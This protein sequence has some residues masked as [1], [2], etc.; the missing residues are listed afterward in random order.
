[1][2]DIVRKIILVALGLIWLT[3]VYLIVVNAAKTQGEYASTSP[4]QATGLTGLVDNVVAAWERG[5]LGGAFTSTILYSVTGPIVAVLIGAAAGY[6]IV[7]LQL[8]RGF[9]WFV[10]IFCSSIF[11]IQML[12]MPLFFWYVDWH[13]YNTR[14]GLI[15]IYAVISVSFSAFVMRNFFTGI[16]HQVFEAAVVDG[17]SAWRIFW[18]IYLPL[19]RPALIALFILQAT[20]VWNDLLLGLTLTKSEEIRPLMASLAALTGNYGGSTAPILLAGGLIVSI[21]TVVLFLSTQRAF[22][23]GLSLGQ[24]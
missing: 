19:A 8:R 20:G 9:M 23:R 5:E 11:P 13:L 15:L 7:A 6:A 10:L 14:W 17:A 24:F 16:A 21:P 18:G 4:W 3:P 22:S 12:L 1:M 2:T